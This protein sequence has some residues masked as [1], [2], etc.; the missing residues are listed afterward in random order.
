MRWNRLEPWLFRDGQQV[1]H[2][3]KV[4][5]LRRYQIIVGMRAPTIQC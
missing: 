3:N 5:A 4:F 1:V 2:R